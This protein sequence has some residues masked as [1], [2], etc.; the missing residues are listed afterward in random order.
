SSEKRPPAR[1]TSTLGHHNLPPGEMPRR[2]MEKAM[3]R[4]SFK[5]VA[6]ALLAAA[7]GGAAVAQGTQAQQ[8]ACRGDVFRLCANYIPDVG[9]IVAS[10]RGND[11]R[12]SDA[13]H[14]VVL[15]AQTAAT[16]QYS[17]PSRIRNGWYR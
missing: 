3:Y 8:D 1:G 9:Q 14:A 13:C 17:T 2:S 16:D 11:P 10:L 7:L 6:G 5:L 4:T 12:L 15:E